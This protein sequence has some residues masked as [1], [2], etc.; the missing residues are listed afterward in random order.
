MLGLYGIV[1]A[2][3]EIIVVSYAI[4]L[5]AIANTV[6]WSFVSQRIFNKNANVN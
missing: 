2:L 3:V 4:K 1:E 5:I 6:P